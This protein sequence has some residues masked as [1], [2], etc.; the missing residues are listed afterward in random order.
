[1]SEEEKILGQLFENNFNCYTSFETDRNTI[2][3]A[4]AMTK[5]KFIK[6]VS[7]ELTTLKQRNAELVEALEKEEKEYEIMIKGCSSGSNEWY[8]EKGKQTVIN[9]FKQALER[10]K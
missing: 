9:K 5:D 7:K 3:S 6:V 4:M 8:Y 10:N 2:G 1:M